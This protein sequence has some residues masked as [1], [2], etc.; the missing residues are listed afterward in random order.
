VYCLKVVRSS[1]W[2]FVLGVLALTLAQARPARAQVD[3]CDEPKVQPPAGSPVLLKCMQLVAHPVNETVVEGTTYDFHIKTTRPPNADEEKPVWVPY[4]EA[5][6]QNDFWNLWRAGFLDNLWIEILDEPYKSGVMGKHVVFHI[7]ERARVKVVDYAPARGE[8]L[9]IEQSKIEETLR[10]KQINIRLDSFVDQSVIRRVKGVLAELYA[11]KGYSDA[12]ISTTLTELPSG[13]KLVQL[14]FTIDEG[15]KIKIKEVV[16]DGNQAFSD[17]KLRG[18]MKDNKAGG[19]LSFITGAT[20]YAPNKMPDDADK[21]TEFYQNKGY[22]RAVVGSHQVETISDSRDG[23]TRYIRLRIPVDEGQRYKVGAFNVADNTLVR[24]EFLKPLFKVKEGEWY[25]AKKIRKGLQEVQKV[26]GSA[27]FYQ[28]NPGVEACPRGMNCQTMEPIPGQEQLPIVDVTVRM[29]EGKRFFVNRLSFSGNTTT[30]D[31]VVRREMRVYEGGVFNSEGLKESIR[32]LNQLGYFKPIEGTG[33][34]IQIKPVPGADDRVDLGIKVEEQ[35][36]NQLSFGAGVSQFDGFF[37]QLS[38]QTSNF[39]GRGETVGVSLQ[40][41]SQARQYQVSFSEPYLWDRPITFGADVFSRQVRYPLVYSQ[42]S[43]GTNLVVGYPL[44]DYTRLFVGY[45]YEKIRVFD[46]S[47]AYASAAA[48]AGNPALRAALLLDQN[49]R[50]TVSKVTPSVVFNTVNHPIFPS[51]GRKLTAG[52]EL[53]GLGGTTSFIQTRGDAIWYI[54]V[55][56]KMAIGLHGEAQYVVPRG[57]TTTLPIFEKFFQG[58]EY[59]VRGFDL[60]TIGPRDPISNLVIGGNKSLLFNAEYYFTIASPVRV[61]AFFDAGQVRDFGEKFLWKEPI[62]TKV[63]PNQ[64]LLFGPIGLGGILTPIGGNPGPQIVKTGET[65]AFKT[66]VGGEV[67]FFMP[68]LNVPFRLIGA[69]NP[70]RYGVFNN[71]LRPQPKYTFRFAV[72]VTF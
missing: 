1:K 28:F 38:F 17:G 41:G 10:E 60:R 72:G 39:L 6:I 29:V 46:V 33:E 36:R 48:L 50:Q 53:A 25:S 56:A 66:S 3:P 51:T 14:T 19:M 44:A 8:K 49:G 11:E 35:N 21:I 65:Y 47:A 43:R 15:P 40:R 54:P 61:L 12:T 26:Y 67:R 63:F 5:S 64:P 42:E 71:N 22:A 27:G 45:S 69:Y 20:S 57:S 13:P 23:K 16:F 30:R 31:N 62:T 7:E 32:R 70:S 37:G 9:K 34:V 58:G 68:V 24:S 59:S 2:W 4:D 18:Q 52:V 55:S